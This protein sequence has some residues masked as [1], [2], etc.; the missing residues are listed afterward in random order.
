MPEQPRRARRNDPGRRDRIVDSCLAVIVEAGVAGAS[1]RRI[2]E[3]ADVSLGSIT[4]YFSGM[5]ALLREAFTRFADSVADKF[6]ARM[7]AATDPR[8]AGAAVVAII[9]D[10]VFGQPGEL[11][12]TH[13]LYALAA[14]DPSFR[15]ITTAW[16]ARSRA[17]LERHFDPE[18]ARMLDALI[19]GLSIHRALDVDPCDPADVALAVARITASV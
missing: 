15:D 16:M 3:V 17:A 2:A 18:T 19:E 1:A 9:V 12:V 13:E 8:S 7:A 5:N 6:E 11:Q 14:R 4:Y 10:D